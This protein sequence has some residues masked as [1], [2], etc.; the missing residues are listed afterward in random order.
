MHKISA[1][2]VSQYKSSSDIFFFTDLAH[3]MPITKK[4]KPNI[5]AGQI[6]KTFGASTLFVTF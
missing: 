3:K 1:G 5:K 2:L 4:K 6:P